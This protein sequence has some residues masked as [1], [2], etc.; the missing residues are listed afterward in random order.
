MQM[1]LHTSVYK[2]TQHASSWKADY[3]T[4]GVARLDCSHTSMWHMECNWMHRAIMCYLSPV[5]KIKLMH[6]F[7]DVMGQCDLLNWVPAQ[8]SPK[9]FALW[10]DHQTHHVC[11]S[12]LSLPLG[13]GKVRCSSPMGAAFPAKNVHFTWAGV[14]LA[15]FSLCSLPVI[16][17]PS[18]TGNVCSVGEQPTN[19]TPVLLA[20]GILTYPESYC[21]YWVCCTS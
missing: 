15:S 5:Q 10:F 1:S 21:K 4:L 20:L 2:P 14:Y 18:A 9:S 6:W 17:E 7:K 11:S 8:G 16:K 19:V 12:C 3:S 13:L